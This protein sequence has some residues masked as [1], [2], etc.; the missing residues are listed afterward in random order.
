MITAKDHR[1]MNLAAKAAKLSTHHKY[2]YG[3]IIVKAGNVLGMGINSLNAAKTFTKPHR[4][5]MHLHSEVDALL[6]LDRDKVKNSTVYVI[7][8]TAA[9]N[10]INAKPCSTC[11]SFLDTMKVKR[12]VYMDID[13]IKELR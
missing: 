6:G 3:S 8:L 7:G 10:S 4:H 5:N 13:T 2:R 11:R 1:M 9:G 12:V